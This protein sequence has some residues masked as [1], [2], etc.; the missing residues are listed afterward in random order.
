MKVYR[1]ASELCTRP[2]GMGTLCDFWWTC[3]SGKVLP[4]P[5]SGPCQQPKMIDGEVQEAVQGSEAMPDAKLFD[6][7]RLLML[8]L[9]LMPCVQGVAWSS[10]QFSRPPTRRR[11]RL[12][13][14]A[15]PP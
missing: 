10:P 5:A 3:I 11:A 14:G 7:L 6:P 9:M 12:A 2:D 8:M 13:D 15:R 4:S 1:H